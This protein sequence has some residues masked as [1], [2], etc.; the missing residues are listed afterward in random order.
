LRFDLGPTLSAHVVRAYGAT[1]GGFKLLTFQISD[2]RE[3]QRYG[4]IIADRVWNA[5]WRNAGRS[6]SDVERHVVEMA[7][8]HPLPMAVVAHDD[9]G[10]LGSAFLIHSDMEERPQYS[11]WVAAVWVEAAERRRGVGRALIAEAAKIAGSLGYRVVY[12][13]CRQELE[14]F[15]SRIG[16][17]VVEQDAGAKRL[18]ILKLDLAARAG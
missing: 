10:Y 3:Q 14:G 6:V 4:A 9:H 15:Y 13:C 5:W 16:W 7:H 2:F 1:G 18:S 11:P 17:Q 8:D 12:I